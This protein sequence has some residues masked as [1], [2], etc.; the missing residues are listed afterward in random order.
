MAITPAEKLDLAKRFHKARIASDFIEGWVAAGKP[1]PQ[2]VD[3]LET[4]TDYHQFFKSLLT[5]L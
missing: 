1:A 3:E 5:E 4:I 2:P